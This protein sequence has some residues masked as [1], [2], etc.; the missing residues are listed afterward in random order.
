MRMWEWVS[1]SED[2]TERLGQALAAHL[3]ERAVVAL[4]GTLGSG[5]T[6]LV[7]A[8]AAAVGIERRSVQSPTFVLVHEY[9]GRVPIF[10]FDAYRLRDLDDFRNLGAEEYFERPG[11]CLI[12]WAEKVADDLPWERLDVRLEWLDEAV[13]RA[14]F[15][16]RGPRFEAVLAAVAADL[17]PPPPGV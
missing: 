13:R 10:H 8:I 1:T 3:P 7:Q 4:D 15:T 14:E 12:E 16:A 17:T 6:R 11:W 9:D 2:E 5:K